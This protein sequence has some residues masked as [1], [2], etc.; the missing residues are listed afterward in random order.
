[1]VV[2]F[3]LLGPAVITMDGQSVVLPSNK[4]CIVLAALLLRANEFVSA[5]HLYRAV[6]G[7]RPPDTARA[8]LQTYVLRL[9]RLL[10]RY[11]ATE[12]LIRT[13]PQGYAVEADEDGL[14]VLRF[15]RIAREARRHAEAGALVEESRCLSD[16]LA[17]WRGPA[18]GNVRSELLQRDEVPALTEERLEL[19]E[20][21]GEV[22]LALGRYRELIPE[23]WS[24]TAAHPGRERFAEQ[25]VE[26]L[27]RAGR[28]GEALA[29]YR[30]V[31]STLA[32]SLGIDPG[33]RLRALELT[34]LRGDPVPE[35]PRWAEGARA[36]V[37]VRAPGRASCHLPPAVPDF[38][39]RDELVR[40]LAG[41]LTDRDA[42]AAV[43]VISGAPGV[44]KTA[45]AVHIAHRVRHA[46]PDGQWFVR[47]TTPGGAVRDPATALTELLLALGAEPTGLSGRIGALSARFRAATSGRRVLLVVDDAWGIEHV[48]HLLPGTAGSAVLVTSRMSLIGLTALRGIGS[49]R[50]E[51]LDADGSVRLLDRLLDGTA[52]RADRPA[53]RELAEL[54]GG[55]PLALRIAAT[56]MR[57]RNVPDL[58]G[59]VSWLRVD[60]LA[61]L[62]V[63]SQPP[64]S[65]RAAFDTS[66]RR[67][68]PRT[69][70][71]FDVV[72]AAPAGEVGPDRVAGRL[73]VAEHEAEELLDQL[74]DAGLVSGTAPGR[75]GMSGLL[76]RYAA[77][78]SG[79]AGRDRS[80]DLF[81]PTPVARGR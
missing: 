39:G 33:P 25:L 67:L 59:Y 22:E 5:E 31:R 16:A 38:V 23:L 73:G 57:H 18:L 32:G 28:Q 21:R 47:L 72:G 69:R 62:S 27:Y 65:V 12:H 20:R 7:D 35:R 79:A 36:G 46:F 37:A 60:P 63:G 40:T 50:L 43:A 13:V 41:Q 24:A 55:L 34:I 9:R 45:T 4:P 10:T 2:R 29:E 17:L 42:E 44:G 56:K 52:G 58:A 61:R 53:V 26:A 8:T 14:D 19:V 15:R 71:V 81:E 48:E 3:G 49:H 54:C 51:P 64:I 11:G 70:R 78:R 6:W 76:R 1:M 68:E 77:D 74:L 66:Y 80:D 30:R 75:Y